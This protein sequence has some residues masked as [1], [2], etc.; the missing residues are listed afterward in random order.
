MLLMQLTSGCLMHGSKMR[1]WNWRLH[2]IHIKFDMARSQ[3]HIIAFGV[4]SH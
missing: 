3:T 1:P 4:E 2:S